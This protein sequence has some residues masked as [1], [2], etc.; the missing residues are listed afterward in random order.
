MLSLIWAKHTIHMYGPVGTLYV[1]RYLLKRNLNLKSV[2]LPS[3]SHFSPVTIYDMPAWDL[4]VYW[5]GS[6]D[7]ILNLQTGGAVFPVGPFLV[8]SSS[9]SEQTHLLLSPF[10]CFS[11]TLCHC[12]LLPALKASA[13]GTKV[14][15]R[16]HQF[17]PGRAAYF[18][19]VVLWTR[20]P[21]GVSLQLRWPLSGEH[22]VLRGGSNLINIPWSPENV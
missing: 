2:Q 21:S 18:Q 3:P 6:E 12:P 9:V 5:F 15:L 19:H 7:S 11:N 8:D 14:C 20:L 22:I 1:F 17:Q 13:T 16:L 4:L 10:F